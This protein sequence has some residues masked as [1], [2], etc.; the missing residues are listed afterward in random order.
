[1]SLTEK[2]FV[3]ELETHTYRLDGRI[4][5]SVTTIIR[6]FVPAYPV[7]PWYMT[8][9]STI[10]KAIQKQ[11]QVGIDWPT[12][13][14]QLKEALIEEDACKILGRTK[15]ALKFIGDQ[16]IIVS[17][18]EKSVYSEI[19]QFAGTIDLV[20]YRGKDGVSTPNVVVDWKGTWTPESALQLAAYRLAAR[21]PKAGGCVVELHDNGIPRQ[22][23]YKPKELDKAERIF[24]SM[25]NV[26]GWL[27]QHK[28]IKEEP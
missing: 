27:K 3:F 18:I 4:L 24:T 13:E 11:L 15:A 5:P 14:R 16:Y 6:H 9:G 17:E 10:H 12:W 22:V 21:L 7:D 26:Y 23:W 20:A 2:G 28:H 25:V 1:M 8:R 19:G